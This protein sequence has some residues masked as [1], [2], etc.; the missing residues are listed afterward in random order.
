MIRRIWLELAH[1]KEA[2]IADIGPGAGLMA[3][4]ELAGSQTR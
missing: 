2:L 1:G 4:R 3:M